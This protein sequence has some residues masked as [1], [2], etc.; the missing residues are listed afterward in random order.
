M[1]STETENANIDTIKS[2]VEAIN[3]NDIERELACWQPDGEFTVVPT[4]TMYKGTEQIR[5]AGKE[6]AAAVGGQP[7]EGRKQITHIDAGHDWAVVQYDTKATI[8]GPV[9]MAGLTL[10]PAGV[11]KEIETKALVVFQMKDNKIDKAREYFD[12]SEMAEQL[13]LDQTTLAKMYTAL[14]AK[15]SAE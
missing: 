6:S 2:W 3:N 10:V 14:G 9:E 5:Q 1:T 15:D 8:T 12:P 11:K 13:G 7:I 4:G